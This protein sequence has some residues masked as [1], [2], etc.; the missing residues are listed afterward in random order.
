MHDLAAVLSR[1]RPDIDDP[2]RGANRVLVVL[3]D[4][5]G[6]AEIPQ[7]LQGIQEFA[8]VSLVEADRGLV[9]YVQHARETGTNLRCEANALGLAARQ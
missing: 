4:D 5:E 6:V 1:E 9:E 2:V 3:D 8:I 7:P